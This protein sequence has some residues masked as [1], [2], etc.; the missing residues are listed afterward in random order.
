MQV[1]ELHRH[2]VVDRTCAG[3]EALLPLTFVLRGGVNLTLQPSEYILRA[4]PRGSLQP[5]GSRVLLLHVYRNLF[6]H[7]SFY[8]PGNTHA[9]TAP[10]SHQRGALLV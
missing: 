10:S 1:I 7:S 8:N 3:I 4:R 6:G 5:R 2:L 9:H